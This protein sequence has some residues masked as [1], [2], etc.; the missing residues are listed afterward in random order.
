MS[1]I[2]Q[3]VTAVKQ[4]RFPPC[5]GYKTDVSHGA[6]NTLS[7]ANFASLTAPEKKKTQLTSR[8]NIWI[9]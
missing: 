7:T 5:L 1:S 9:Q 2:A 3:G 8:F 6:F 4:C